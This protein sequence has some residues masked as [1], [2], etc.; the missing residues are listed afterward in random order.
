MTQ[1]NAAYL[2]IINKYNFLILLDAC[3]HKLIYQYITDYKLI[4]LP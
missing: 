4:I 3:T 1:N 2:K